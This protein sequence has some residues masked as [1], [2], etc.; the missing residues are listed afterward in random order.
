MKK[1]FEFKKTF[2]IIDHEVIRVNFFSEPGIILNLLI[3]S[4]INKDELFYYYLII[5]SVYTSLRFFK[6]IVA[7]YISFKKMNN[8]MN[9]VAREILYFLCAIGLSTYRY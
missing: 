2:N 8:I 3:I 6:S 5:I 7:T 1:I 4:L 9:I